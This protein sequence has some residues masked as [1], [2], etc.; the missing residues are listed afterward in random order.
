MIAIDILKLFAFGLCCI[1][2]SKRHIELFSDL[3]YLTT[4]K[5]TSNTSSIPHRIFLHRSF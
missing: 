3:K 4:L 2:R 1:E 5:R